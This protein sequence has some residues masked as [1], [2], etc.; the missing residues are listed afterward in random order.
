MKDHTLEHTRAF[1]DSMAEN[2]DASTEYDPAKTA[3][4]LK[5]AG[6]PEH[7]RILDV[8]CGTGVLFPE[9]LAFKPAYLRAI[10]LSPEMVRAAKAKFH[11]I[12]VTAEDFY[13]FPECGFDVITLYNAYPH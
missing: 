9:L 2:W 10:D 11:E 7:A 8:A 4:M 13:T 12:H 3:A 5:I 6:V 1:F